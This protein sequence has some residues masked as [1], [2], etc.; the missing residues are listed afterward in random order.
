MGLA[1]AC[2]GAYRG[3]RLDLLRQL[4]IPDIH[5]IGGS[6]FQKPLGTW[7]FWAGWGGCRGEM[8]FGA[9]EAV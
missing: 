9:Q 5:N 6:W 4:I 8:N 2:Y 1:M 3:Y 7:T